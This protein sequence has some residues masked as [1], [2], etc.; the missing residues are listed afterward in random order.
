MLLDHGVD[1]NARREDGRTAYALAH[2][3][4]ADLL[5]SRGASTELPALDQFLSECIAAPPA[6]LEQFLEK[7]RSMKVTPEEHRLPPDMAMSHST[8]AVR[9]LLAAGVPVDA[10]G[11][12]GAT[13]LH[14]ACWKGYADIV[15]IMLQHGASLTIEDTMFHGTPPGWFGHGIQNCGDGGGDYPQV[16][17]E[18]AAVGAVFP[19]VDFPS[20]NAEVDQVLREHGIL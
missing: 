20:G 9:A 2:K 18:L 10:R 7:A 3:R 1:V 14:W 8:I 19:K 17:R 16:A 15:R 4:I 6:E 11:Q 5:A 13:A 12:N